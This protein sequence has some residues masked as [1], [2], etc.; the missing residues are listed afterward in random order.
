[1]K[2]IIDQVTFNINNYSLQEYGV[3]KLA[4]LLL[5][6]PIAYSNVIIKNKDKYNLTLYDNYYD[7]GLIYSIIK[8]HTKLFKNHYEYL[9]TPVVF[10]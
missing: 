9:N 5:T 3:G 7:I 10:N 6:G 1:M 4:V 8:N 2:K